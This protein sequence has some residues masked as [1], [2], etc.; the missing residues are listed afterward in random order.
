MLSV[1][2]IGLNVIFENEHFCFA[3]IAMLR[4]CLSIFRRV[5]LV[6]DYAV[7]AAHAALV[8][9]VCIFIFCNLLKSNNKND[10]WRHAWARSR[11]WVLAECPAVMNCHGGA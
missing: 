5:W 8:L 9:R 10:Y 11:G 6:G 4:W 3:I 1:V 7:A 2:R